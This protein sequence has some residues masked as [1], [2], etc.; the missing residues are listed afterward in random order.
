M[1][2]RVLPTK[3]VQYLLLK[4]T[5]LI[6]LVNNIMYSMVFCWGNNSVQT[7][8]LPMGAILSSIVLRIHRCNNCIIIQEKPI[9]L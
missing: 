2:M 9:K 1:H 7:G 8:V 5:A 3:F 4:C 6:V